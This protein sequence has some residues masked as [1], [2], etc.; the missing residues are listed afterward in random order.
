MRRAYQVIRLVLVVALIGCCVATAQEVLANFLLGSDFSK[1]HTYK[2]ITIEGGAHSNQ[3]IDAHIK[4]AFESQLASKGLSRTD[5]DKVDLYVG[6][7]TAVD[8]R[9]TWRRY[10]V[11][12]AH[13]VKCLLLQ[14]RRSTLGR[15][16]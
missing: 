10:S 9:K 5:N 15:S 14:A 2:W 6:Y 16:F 3:S 1:Y 12:G 7:Q 11:D 13:G 4:Q 8:Q